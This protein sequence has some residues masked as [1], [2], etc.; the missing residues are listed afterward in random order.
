MQSHKAE[1]VRTDAVTAD[2]VCGMKVDPATARHS[3]TH[4]GIT[5]Y[6]CCEGCRAK[7]AAAPAKYLAAAT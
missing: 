1:R 3:H 6:F 2:P 5:Y 7:F 4:D